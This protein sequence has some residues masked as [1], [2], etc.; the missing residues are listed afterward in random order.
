MKKIPTILT[1][2][3]ETTTARYDAFVAGQVGMTI[4]NRAKALP[5]PNRTQVTCSSYR[6][7][8][9]SRVPFWRRVLRFLKGA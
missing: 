3:V 4:D 8:Y 5:E 1:A 9:L 6:V 7:D 2:R